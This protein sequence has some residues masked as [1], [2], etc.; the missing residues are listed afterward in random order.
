MISRCFAFLGWL[1]LS[2]FSLFAQ[3]TPPDSLLPEFSDQLVSDDWPFLVGYEFDAQGRMFAYTKDGKVW[4]SEDG[5]RP[6]QPLIDIS[7][8]V[9]NFGDHGLNALEL[10]PN[11]ENNGYVYLLY[12]VDRHHLFN[13]GTPSYREQVNEH[14]FPTI[15]RLVR[16]QLDAASNFTR[17]VDSSRQV[18]IGASIREGIPLLHLSHG[19]GDL[20]WGTD[21]SLLVSAGDG[22]SYAGEDLGDRDDDAVDEGILEPGE[23]V[24]VFRSQS[25][26]SLSGKILRLDPLTGAGLSSNPFFR[27]DQP[28]APQSMVWALGL[29]NPYRFVV[30]PQTG[31]HDIEEGK[32]GVLLVSDVGWGSWEEWNR[33]DAPGQNFG[34]PL[35]EGMDLQWAYYHRRIDNVFVPNPRYSL[36]GCDQPYLAYNDLIKNPL[37]QGLPTFSNPCDASRPLPD[38]IRTYLHV[39][40]LLTYNN[41]NF[42][43][44]DF[45][46]F[47]PTFADDGTLT[48]QKIDATDSPVT[49]ASFDGVCT[50]GGVW[51]RGENFPVEYRGKLFMGDYRGWI[52]VATFDTLTGE[53][54]RIEPFMER[55]NGPARPIGLGVHPTDGCLWYVDYHGAQTTLRRICYGGNPPPRAVISLDQSYGS[56][57]LRVQFRGDGSFD[58]DGDSLAYRWDFG[59]GSSSEEPNPTHTF[60]AEGTA[61]QAFQVTLTV[62][63]PAGA[64]H[65]RAVTVSLNNTPPQVNITSV[66][67]GA[68]YSMSGISNVPLK[69]R[70]IDAEH[71]GEELF[72]RWQVVLHHNDHQHPEPFDTARVSRAMLIPEGCGTE[73]YWY[74][75]HLEVR[76]AAGL[77]AQDEVL[78]YPYCGAPANVFGPLEVGF[79]DFREAEIRWQMQQQTPGTVYVVEQS[80][81]QQFFD[82]VGQLLAEGTTDYQFLQKMPD[83]QRPYY[84]IKAISPDSLVEFS[85]VMRSTFWGKTPIW[86]YP[87]PVQQKLFLSM[88]QVEGAAWI[89]IMDL[90]G[91]ILSTHTWPGNASDASFTLK[92][93]DLSAGLYLYRV[94]DGRKIEVGRF[95]KL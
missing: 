67:D 18:L 65:R 48:R 5:Q 47:V 15:G 63:D 36:N 39:P 55:V 74:R 42:N 27:A 92:V 25:I 40:P 58:P 3:I 38:S 51:Y 86:L 79:F 30:M 9:A 78:V 77:A 50:V 24:G 60:T 19:L 72:Y 23:D 83:I 85:G 61:P 54:V 52:K 34:W 46:T 88:E 68:Q 41:S 8:E 7:E 70:V 14:R 56:T 87:N 10:H 12:V 26:H 11:F 57:P 66:A 91:R 20:G 32:P 21:G 75:I 33:V 53:L 64:S 43:T 16:Y 44:R 73:D 29:R 13:F 81:D 69:A 95:R 76:D 17:L 90:Q 71:A 59:D 84:R 82:P 28:R 94:S 1:A 80:A 22:A 6:A 4:L 35:Y 49:G 37:A 2:L 62:T 31:S 93:K 89:E 45:G